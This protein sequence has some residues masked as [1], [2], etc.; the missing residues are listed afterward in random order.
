MTGGT[1][2]AAYRTST[3]LGSGVAATACALFAA[4]HGPVRLYGSPDP[5][6]GGVVEC[7]P[8]ATLTLLLELGLVPAELGVHALVRE[9]WVSWDGAAPEYRIGP[10]CAHLDRVRLCAALWSRVD[11]HPAVEVRPRERKAPTG[12]PGRVVDATGGRSLTAIEV[13]R[14]PRP[15]VAATITVPSGRADTALHLAAAPEGYAYRLASADRTTVGWVGPG[16]PPRDA[17]ALWDIVER[18]GAGWLLAGVAAAA[19][20]PTCRRP[21]GPSLPVAGPGTVPIGDAALTRD[22]LASQGT[23]IALSDA[24]LAADP[25][26]SDATLALRRA[27]ARYRHLRHLREMADTCRFADEP[28]WARYRARLRTLAELADAPGRGPGRAAPPQDG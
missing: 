11:A 13:A 26:T 24:C 16:R 27:D 2:T 14:D 10:A 22:A 19:T 20:E 25:R 17:G 8:A 23:A 28:A 12:E 3:V 18:A 9:R 21:T 7:V 15:W 1:S 4:P 6:P 5:R